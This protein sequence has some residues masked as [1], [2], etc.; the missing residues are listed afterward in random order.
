MFQ[1][2]IVH[3]MHYPSIRTIEKC[4]H[5]IREGIFAANENGD[6]TDKTFTSEHDW[7]QD[8]VRIPDMI[9]VSKGLDGSLAE[10]H[11]GALCPTEQLRLTVGSVR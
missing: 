8:S 5:V 11:G 1:N 3:E 6:T 7:W 2:Q 9:C 10:Q 4:D